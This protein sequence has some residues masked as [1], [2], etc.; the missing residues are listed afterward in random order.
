[1]AYEVR[2]AFMEERMANIVELSLLRNT[3]IGNVEY[4]FNLP[5]PHSIIGAMT[6]ARAR[7]RRRPDHA[8]ALMR[9]SSK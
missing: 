1:V 2:S 7:S 8:A 6:P 3:A 4:F 9:S 5:F